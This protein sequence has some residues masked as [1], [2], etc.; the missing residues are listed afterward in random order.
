M[1]LIQVLLGILYANI[2]EYS[3]HR[4]LFHGL[5]K[6]SSSIFAFH[7]RGHHMVARKNDFYDTRLSRFETLGMLLLVFIHTPVMFLFPAFY[8][9]T[10]AYAVLF[11]LIHNVLHR[12][13]NFAHKYFWWHW[14]HHMGNQ[15]KSWGVVLPITDILTGTLEDQNVKNP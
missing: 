13:A 11:I 8:Y 4:Y 7:L 12:N 15:N 5:G 14:N 1:I 10:A 2:L 9:S 6:S 3:I